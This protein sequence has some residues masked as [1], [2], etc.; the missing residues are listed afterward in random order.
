MRNPCQLLQCL[1]RDPCCHGCSSPMS[2][3]F[4]VGLDISDYQSVHTEFL[5][6][7]SACSTHV[8]YQMPGLSSHALLFFVVWDQTASRKFNFGVA[9]RVTSQLPV[10][11]PI[12]TPHTIK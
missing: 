12:A 6:P 11:R 8:L 9:P 1:Q 7:L 5:P 3:A 4:H 10:V 2:L